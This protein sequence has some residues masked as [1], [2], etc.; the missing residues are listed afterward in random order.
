MKF[1]FL[2]LLFSS[3]SYQSDAQ[4]LKKIGDKVKQDAEWRVRYKADRQVDKALDSVIEAPRKIIDKKKE[5]NKNKTTT[6]SGDNNKENVSGNLNSTA[7]DENDM[8]PKDGFI[9]LQLSA[10]TVFA[11]GT[12]LI[13]GES[14]KYKSLNQVEVTINGPST[15]DVK[16]VA[17]TADG[18]FTTGWYASDKPGEYIVTAKSSD[19]KSVQSA[20]FT[21]YK[22]PGLEN[23]CD[24]NIAVT[25]K[26]YDK[27]KDEVDRVKGEISSK[28][29]AELQKKIDEIKENVDAAIKLFQDLNTAGKEI[30]RLAKSGT[31][32]SPNLAGNLSALNNTLE[33]QRKK[34]KQIEEFNNHEPS[35]NTICEYLV[36]VNEACAAFSVYTNIECLAI[37]G[38]IK[39]IALDKGVPTTVGTMVNNRLPPDLEFTGKE[40]AKI[41]ATSLV[42]AESLSTKLG[43][44]GFAGDLV[45]FAT[46]VLMKKYCGVFK[47]HLTHN[48]TIEF[49]NSSGQNWWTYGVEM[50]AALFLRYP[51]ENSKGNIIK[52]KGNLE[53]NGTKFTFFEDVEKEDGFHE[54]TRGKIEVVPIKVFTPLAVSEATSER[55]ILGFGAIARGMATPAYF[56]IPI[57]AEYDVDAEKIKI[58]LNPPIIDFSRAVSNQF[59][60]LLVGADLI[61]YIKRIL[62]PIN[63]A[64]VT[65][66]AVIRSNNEFSVD[67]DSKGNLSFTGK[68]NKHIGDKTTTRET[69]LNFTI[70]AKKE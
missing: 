36:M 20:K 4:L 1:L 18:K 28:D 24:E 27:L 26:A 63:K 35:D 30:A 38:I 3:Y 9:T 53:G 60:F 6:V 12:L 46:D 43:Q 10:T 31:N 42:D 56:N 25:N 19:K 16:P 37:K 65:L 8:T 21:V 69:E 2:L 59:V 61:P 67:K 70:T 68:G 41:F 5:K 44:A 7:S 51:K 57:D 47:G 17:L 45:Q 52:M 33:D 58:F 50:K 49:R 23:W 14:V 39:N 15:K 34:M 40:S 48:Y 29:K 62:F 54:G 13:S 55:D 32:L 11:G 22:L 64:N 66:G